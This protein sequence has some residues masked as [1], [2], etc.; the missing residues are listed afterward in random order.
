M[1]DF[2]N[3]MV[4]ASGYKTF[5]VMI[6]D[7]F[8]EINLAKPNSHKR[9]AHLFIGNQED[10]LILNFTKIGFFKDNEYLECEPIDLGYVT[11]TSSELESYTQEEFIVFLHEAYPYVLNNYITM[12]RF[13][14]TEKLNNEWHNVLEEQ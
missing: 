2:I 14:A 6:F 11:L 1:T 12:Q 7:D 4:E 8:C 13:Y 9:F 10:D 3:K 5:N